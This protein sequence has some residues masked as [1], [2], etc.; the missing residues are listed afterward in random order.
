MFGVGSGEILVILLVALLLLGPKDIPKVA[1]TIGRTMKDL[2]RFKD[3]LRRS[4]DMEFEEYEK[5]E[6]EV[7]EKVTKEKDAEDTEAKEA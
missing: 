2:Q 6:N 7:K 3:D 1:R 4:V 5:L